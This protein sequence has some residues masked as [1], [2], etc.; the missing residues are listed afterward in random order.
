MGLISL[1]DLDIEAFFRRIGM[2][3][4]PDEPLQRLKVLHRSMTRA[5]P[6]ENIAIL[7]GKAISLELEDILDKV[8]EQKRGGYCF[9]LN[10]LLA[11]VLKALGYHV[12]RLIGRVWA[13]GALAPP[14][15][16]M[17]IRVTLDNQRYLCDVGFGGGTLREP[18]P[19]ELATDAVQLHDRFRLEMT[20]NGETML[21]R[22]ANKGWKSLY[23]LLP[24]TV[25]RQDYIPANHYT[26]T[27]P[28]SFFTQEPVAALLTE[29]SR[30]TLRGRLFR[31]VNAASETERELTSLH[32]LLT[33]LTDDFGLRNLD[34]DALSRR[35]YRLF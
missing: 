2:H 30:I 29:N 13:N 32:E 12:E 25:R 3:S 20:D 23:S 1:S 21:S 22:Q 6:F 7:E 5:V 8:V 4:L 18:L 19:W 14:L 28:D 26:S 31:R 15:T 10:S 16:H 9:E 27:H 17:A 24:C 11:H 33:V 35:L 34:E